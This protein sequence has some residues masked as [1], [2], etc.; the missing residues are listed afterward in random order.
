ML[1]Y[2]KNHYSRRYISHA[3]ISYHI[4]SFIFFPKSIQ[5]YKIHVDMERVIFV[6]IKK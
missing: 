2:V 4:I 3:V 6:G 5:D 1:S